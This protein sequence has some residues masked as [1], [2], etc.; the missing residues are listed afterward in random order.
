MPKHY[1]KKRPG[2]RSCAKMVTGDAAKALSMAY[3]LK[4]LINVEYH[5]ITTAW[6]TD[7]NTS[8]SV[9]NLT[10]I[11]QGDD[12]ANRQGRKI[13]LFSIRSQGS[14][15]VNA[16]STRSHGRSMIVRDNLGSTTQPA[17][18]DMFSSV[19]LFLAGCPRKDDP[20]T[21]SRFT[22]ILDYRYILEQEQ[23]FKWVNH[24]HKIGSHVTYT[25][26]G[27]T[28]EGKGNIY[29]FIASNEA[30]NDPVQSVNTVVKYIDN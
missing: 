7:P 26:T 23:S 3:A 22:V 18:T 14:V 21:N 15:R 11:A 24:Y 6:T 4:K 2:Y 28:D 30:T 13:K 20:Q 12:I 17:I 8:G 9:V 16:S 27:A 19:A 5:S 1:R 25:G 29:L 10:A